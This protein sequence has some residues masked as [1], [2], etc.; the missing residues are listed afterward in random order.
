LVLNQ[1]FRD[2]VVGRGGGG[3]MGVACREDSKAAQSVRAQLGV[4]GGA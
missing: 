4:G 3:E 2:C 1:M